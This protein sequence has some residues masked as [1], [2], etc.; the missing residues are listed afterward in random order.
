VSRFFFNFLT[1]PKMTPKNSFQSRADEARGQGAHRQRE[2]VALHGQARDKP[3]LQPDLSQSQS[4][5][6]QAVEDE[7]ARAAAARRVLLRLQGHVRLD[8]PVP[9]WS[10][11]GGHASHQVP[12]EVRHQ[13]L[14][15]TCIDSHR[16]DADGR[17]RDIGHSE[18]SA[19]LERALWVLSVK[20]QEPREID[21]LCHAEG[22]SEAQNNGQ[23]LRQHHHRMRRIFRS[24]L[25]SF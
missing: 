3:V 10:Q 2:K 25:D 6:V 14:G 11:E 8:E 22:A 5:R 9:V 21:L 15:W 17:A 16:S 20:V 1:N 13:V 24:N 12:A 7:T 4:G 23:H 19:H 18:H